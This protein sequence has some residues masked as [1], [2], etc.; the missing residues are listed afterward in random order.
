MSGAMM[1]A[2]AAGPR[3]R[4]EM[5]W[6]FVPAGGHS[7]AMNTRSTRRQMLLRTARTAA[8]TALATR[9]APL[10]AAP[11]QRGFKI[12]ACEWSLQKSGPE[13][14]TVAKAIGLDGVQVDLGNPGNHMWLRRPEIQQ[15]YLAAARATG[16]AIGGL[17]LAAE[18]DNQKLGDLAT[19]GLTGMPGI[20]LVERQSLAAVLQ[21]LNLNWSGFVRAKDAVRAGKLLKADWFVFGTRTEL[22]HTHAIVV[23]VV[24]RRKIHSAAFVICAGSEYLPWSWISRSVLTA[25]WW[26][27]TTAFW[28]AAH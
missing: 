25:S 11:G 15:A 20:E 1:S 24:K 14:M 19:A 27:Y 18:A 4:P 2:H 10:L 28:N 9:L 8:A 21:E 26:S 17:G 13:V 7:T 6:T 22:N 16:V 12:G 23:R 3:K 5:W